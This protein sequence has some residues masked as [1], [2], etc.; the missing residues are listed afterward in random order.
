MM[1]L[2]L[3]LKERLKA[4]YGGYA[5]LT[6]GIVK[7]VFTLTALILLNQNIGFQTEL[8]EIWVTPLLALLGAFLPYGAIS[9]LLAGV[10]LAHIYAVSLE[11]MLLTTAILVIIAL[12]YYGFQPGDSFWL[13]L[14]PMAIL[15]KIP[16]AV[17][18]LAGLSGS[19]LTIIPVS[20]GVMISY[21]LLYVKQNAGV[22]TNDASVDLAQKYVQIIRAL[23]GNREMFV[24]M[25]ACAVG[26]LVVYLIRNRS[27]N[28]AWML[29]IMFGTIAQL[30][31]VFAGDYLF[32]VSFPIGE[33]VI[34]TLISILLAL[35]YHFFVFSVDYTRT[36]Y[37]H[38]E[39]DDYVYY[40]KA[41]PKLTVSQPE[42]RVQRMNNPGRKHRM[43][44]EEAERE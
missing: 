13:V 9:L 34:G 23:M 27:V 21:I 12:L 24:M 3:E 19:L 17:P 38:F 22:L 4:F 36:E 7:F 37:T 20:C 5:T 44:R 6:D 43:R 8:K 15:L 2:L 41:V 25:G 32:N 28:Y 14:T 42:I 1:M 11:I 31:V 30:T 10:M 29:A 26:I 35:I 33:I 18:L 40:V 39:D 16:L